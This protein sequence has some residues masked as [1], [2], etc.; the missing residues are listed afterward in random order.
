MTVTFREA[1]TI[2][3]ASALF[4][5]GVA[6]GQQGQSA[7][8]GV[9]R[10]PTTLP[11]QSPLASEHLFTLASPAVVKLTIKDEDE[12]EIGVASGFIVSFERKKH[13]IEGQ[14]LYRS[15]IITNYHVIRPAISIDV[16]FSEG[17]VGWA[18][19]VI[20]E[21]ESADLA[22][23][24]VSSLMEPK[25]ALMLRESANPPIG[26]KVYAIGSP[27]GLS[28]TLSEGL[29][30]GYRQRGEHEPWIQITAAISPG[31]SGGPLLSP[32]GLVLGVTT[33]YL[34]ESQNL[35]FALPASEVSRLLKHTE[36]ARP[37]WEGASIR[38]TEKHAFQDA[39]FSFSWQYTQTTPKESPDGQSDQTFERF[40][41][42]QLSAGDQLALLLK[43]REL[44][45]SKQ[46]DEA[47]GMLRRATQADC[48]EYAY[49]AHFALAQAIRARPFAGRKP[50]TYL[51]DAVAPLRRANELNPDFG[52]AHCLLSCTYH[53]MA[54]WPES[55]VEAESV[56]RLMP[57]CYEGYQLRGEAWAAF[58]REE[59]FERDFETACGLRPNDCALLIAKALG[60]SSLGKLQKAA[61]TY[62]DAIK[63]NENYS[64]PFIPH[65]NLGRTLQRMGKYEEAIKSYQKALK[66]A[67]SDA[68]WQSDIEGRIAE[69]HR[70]MQAP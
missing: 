2:C 53:T 3:F 50:V 45:F 16:S 68:D 61:D 42:E 10:H 29:I 44:Y 7:D 32:E 13:D 46:Y 39:S 1:V 67:G 34:S 65:Y 4:A 55:L 64:I 63:L 22:V 51:E 30:S 38:E 27:R 15:T 25:Q 28:N 48:G 20:A 26:T 69:C 60:Y 18:S 62:K 52:P 14:A 37:I 56:V 43:G 54:R 24:S 36:K 6:T 33:A 12:R 19:E 40:R 5:S 66:V 58:G 35:N 9:K 59:A 8:A 31:S 41:E 57:R 11:G 70:M 49:L 47:I 17:H 23:L 21:D